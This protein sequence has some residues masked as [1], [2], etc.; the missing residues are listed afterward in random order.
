MRISPF[1]LRPSL[2]AVALFLA[3]ALAQANAAPDVLAGVQIGSSLSAL[4][5]CH[6]QPDLCWHR[7]RAQAAGKIFLDNAPPVAEGVLQSVELDVTDGSITRIVETLTAQDA[8][9]K[10]KIQAGVLAS[11]KAK[12]AAWRGP[13]RSAARQGEIYL[14]SRERVVATLYLDPRVI[15]LTLRNQNFKFS[16]APDL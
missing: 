10:A 11:A 6:G 2:A 15:E 13:A 9:A 8:Q 3:S 14:W 7:G 4:P 16:E 1:S 12:W 5:E